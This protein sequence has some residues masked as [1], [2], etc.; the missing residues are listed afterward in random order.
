MAAVDTVG[1]CDFAQ[2]GLASEEGLLR[3]CKMIA[4]LSGQ[5]FSAEDWTALGTQVLKTELAFNKE[6]GF[7]AQKDCLPPMFY[8]E[9]L[10]P[11]NV[12]VKVTPEDLATT[13]DDL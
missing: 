10:A 11:H 4:A 8:K 12:V 3:V 9:P 6:A 5:S 13:F 2:S 7:T 1:I